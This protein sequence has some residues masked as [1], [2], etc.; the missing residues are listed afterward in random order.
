ME[1]DIALLMETLA[2]L[3][4]REVM[5]FKK[6]LSPVHPYQQDCRLQQILLEMADLKNTVV[7]TVLVCGHKFMEKTKEILTKI[8]KTNLV[9][10]LSDSH[11]RQRGKMKIYFDDSFMGSLRWTCPLL[12][13]RSRGI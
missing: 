12:K 3:S 10:R 6:S 8:R 11:S 7:F 9:R 5:Y 13:L 2:D 1:V 4:D